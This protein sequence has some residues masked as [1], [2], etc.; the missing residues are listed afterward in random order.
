MSRQRWIFPP[1]GSGPI[2]AED[3][4]GGSGVMIMPDLPDFV[5]PLD[6]K[7]YS[8]RAG[9]RDHCARHDVVPNAELKG[10]PTLTTNSDMRSYEQKKASADHRKQM[11]IQQVN[12]HYR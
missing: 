1:D 5:S 12:K 2:K 11:L 6:G 4:T 8:G 3:Y 7:L 9:L 10:L